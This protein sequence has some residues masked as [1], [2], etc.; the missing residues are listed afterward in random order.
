M[1]VVL[2]EHSGCVVGT[3]LK[4][5]LLISSFKQVHKRIGQDGRIRSITPNFTEC[6]RPKELKVDLLR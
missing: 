3:I 5:D 6:A 4:P 1:I 2:L